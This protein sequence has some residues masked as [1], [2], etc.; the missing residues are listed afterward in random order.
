MSGH[1]T[2]APQ[3]PQLRRGHSLLSLLDGFPQ[4]SQQRR[5]LEKTLPTKHYAIS[6]HSPGPCTRTSGCGTH[7]LMHL[8]SP[9]LAR[10]QVVGTPA[11][12]FPWRDLFSLYS[13]CASSLDCS[14]PVPAPHRPIS[15]L[16]SQAR[17]LSQT[18]LVRVGYSFLCSP[19]ILCVFT[20]LG[21]P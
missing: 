16:K 3:G 9:H 7:P 14:D 15:P 13:R 19:K 12:H 18:P 21:G 1:A 17:N 10:L 2:Q 8:P 20:V 6:R 11:C 5:R 4:L